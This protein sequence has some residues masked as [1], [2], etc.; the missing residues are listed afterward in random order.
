MSDD[1]AKW[2]SHLIEIRIPSR[3]LQYGINVYD[4]PGFLGNDP[5]ILAENLLQ[6]VSSVRPSLIYL[7]DNAVVSDDS[8]K[9]F[10]QLQLALRHHFRGTAFFFLNTKADVLTIRKDAEDDDDD[11]NDETRG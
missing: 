7:Y 11:D 5:S 1:F 9:C 10:E 4:T 8:R 6:L 3:F 2:A